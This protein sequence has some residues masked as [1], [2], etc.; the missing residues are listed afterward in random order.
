MR[1]IQSHLKNDGI[2]NYNDIWVGVRDENFDD[3]VRWIC[4]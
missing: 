2:A 3:I 4:E 1:G